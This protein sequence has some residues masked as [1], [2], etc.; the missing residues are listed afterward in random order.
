MPEFVMEFYFITY[1]QRM[2]KHEQSEFVPDAMMCE[3]EQTRWA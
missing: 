1:L 2:R 3:T